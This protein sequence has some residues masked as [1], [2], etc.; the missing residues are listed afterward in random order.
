[1]D[2]MRPIIEAKANSMCRSLVGNSSAVNRYT[3]VITIAMQYLPI[4]YNANDS[5]SLPVTKFRYV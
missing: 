3:D 2:P 1:M 4:R 5:S